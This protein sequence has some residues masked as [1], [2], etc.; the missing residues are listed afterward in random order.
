[1]AKRLPYAVPLGRPKRKAAAVL[2]CSGHVNHATVVTGAFPDGRLV[3]GGPLY[4]KNAPP[5][6]FVAAP[7]VPQ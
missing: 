7:G 4:V 6:M 5:V 2:L 1:M 3:S